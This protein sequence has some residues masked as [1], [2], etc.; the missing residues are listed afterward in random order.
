MPFDAA[1]FDFDG[2]L[3]DTMP[4]HYEAYRQIL[5]RHAVNLTYERFLSVSAGTGRN[6]VA[7]LLGCPVDDDI[8]GRIHGEKRRLIMDIFATAPVPILASSHLL[9]AMAGKMPVGLASSGSRPG[10]EV[11]LRRLGWRD[12]FQCIVT[13][14]EISQGKPAPEIYLKTASQLGVEA[15]RC[16][17]FEDTDEGLASARGAG[18]SAVD[19]RRPL[20]TP[21]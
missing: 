15:G 5:A 21:V 16:L 8:V 4:L 2:T 6:T 12:L 19:V 17:A 9:K 7:T 13:G 11:L 18:C 10:I 1:I 20:Q 14:D 3:V